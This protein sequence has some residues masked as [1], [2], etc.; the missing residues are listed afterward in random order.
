VAIARALILEPRVL[1]LDEP[2]SALDV[3]I[4]AEVLNLLDE[5]RRDHASCP[6]IRFH[7]AALHGEIERHY[8]AATAL[9]LPSLAPEVLP[10][11]VL[12]AMACGT[13]VIVR[14]A[15]GAPEP[16]RRAGA[17]FV[18]RNDGELAAA[19]EEMAKPAGPREELSRKARRA[20]EE[21]YCEERYVR[22]YLSLV[23]GGG[24]R[25]RG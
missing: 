22:E 18:Y 3:S 7:G 23:T 6:W 11:T 4:Q 5:L 25:R 15:G 1:L 21:Y 17:G 24:G 12:E 9:I 14:D 16:V 10:L 20:Y 2:T 8:R 13:P 19:I